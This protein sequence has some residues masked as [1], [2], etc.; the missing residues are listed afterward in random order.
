MLRVG[1]IGCGA[2]GRDHCRRVQDLT[3]G[4]Q[5][6]AVSDFYISS[7]ESL[8]EKYGLKV[9]EKG[10]D[11]CKAEDV[12]AVLIACSDNFHAHYVLE[13]MRA[14]KWVFCEKPLAPNPDDCLE[15][16]KEEQ[17]HGK[18]L[19]QVGF[20]RHF[21]PGYVE[22]KRM[23]DMEELGKPLMIHACHR[24]ME[25][26]AGFTTEMAVSNVCIHEI[27]LCRWL[28]NDEYECGQ[29]LVGR[30]NSL[31][32]GK[33]YET[34]QMVL[35]RTKKGILINVEVQPADAFCYD[36]QCQIV[37]ERGT[38]NLPDPYAVI[39]KSGDGRNVPLLKDWKDRFIT[40]YD[41]EFQ[42]WVKAVEAGKLTGPSSWDGYVA[43]VTADTINKTR[44]LGRFLDIDVIDKP[45]IYK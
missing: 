31:A 33:G 41:I 38:V 9:Y 3:P 27:D 36:I 29:V 14:N 19:V 1:I 6:V 10:E 11:L 34:P 32:E 39:K 22:M 26:P 7:A 24:V 18:R 45:D 35:L 2:I 16:M 44:G 12:D 4:A 25:E 13:A 23:A 8:A 5:V 21:D 15:I 42:E 30:Q 40:A 37:F 43:C 20:M 28:V 17:K